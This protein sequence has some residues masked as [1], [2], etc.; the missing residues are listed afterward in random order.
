MRHTKVLVEFIVR[1]R[2]APTDPEKFLGAVGQGHGVEY[3][4]SIVTNALFV[5]QGHRS[6]ARITLVLEKSADFSRVV[7]FSGDSLGNLVGAHEAAMLKSI[8]VALEAGVGRAKDETTMTHEN[9][10]VAATS[11]ERLVKLRSEHLPVYLLDRKGRDI[12]QAPVAQNSVFVMTDHTPMPKKTFN[13]MARQGVKKI[14]VGP[15]MLH[16]AQCITLIWGELDRVA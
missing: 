3:L 9:I 6:D 8:A 13:S 14:S 15:K 4:A 7:T 10:S 12:R 2:S 16:A 11:F 1:A 5:S